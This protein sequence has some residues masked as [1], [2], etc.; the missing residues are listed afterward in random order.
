MNKYKIRF[1][2]KI[3]TSKPGEIYTHRLIPISRKI[4]ANS[5]KEA[6][7]NIRRLYGYD[8]VD[9]TIT[10]CRKTWLSRLLKK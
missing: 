6:R 8:I 7:G 2:Q 1:N 9:L 3:V 5:Y 4:K 10:E